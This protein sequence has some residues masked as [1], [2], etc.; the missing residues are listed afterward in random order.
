M[1]THFGLVTVIAGALAGLAVDGSA[2]RFYPDDPVASNHDTQ[3]ASGVTPFEV[4]AGFDA[5]EHMF[6]NPGDPVLNVRALDVNSIDEVP[7]SSWFTNRAGRLPL[8]AAIVARGPN[9]TDGPAPGPWTV[10][11]AKTA[12]IMPGLVVRDAASVDWFIKFDPPGHR[13]MASGAEVVSTRLLWALGLNV[14]ENHVAHVR[15]ADLVLGPEATIRTDNRKRAMRQA[16]VAMVLER[17]ARGADGTYRVMASRRIA[18][19]PLGPFQFHGIRPD[20]PNDYVRHEHRRVLRAYA[21]WAAWL[22]H[23]DAKSSNT[24]DVLVRQD[25]RSVVRHYLLDFGSTLGSAGVKPREPFEGSEYLFERRSL[26]TSV[27]GFGFVVKPWRVGPQIESAEL[28]ALPDSREWRPEAWKPRFP[29]PAFVRARTDDTFWAAARLRTLTPDLI[30]AAVD[31]ARYEDPASRDAVVQFLVDRRQAILRRGLTAINPVANPR[32]DAAGTLTFDNAAVDADVARIP[33]GYRTE[34]FWFDNATGATTRMGERWSRSTQVT[35]PQ[36]IEP[37][38]GRFVKVEIRAT[39]SAEPAW[40]V[41]VHAYFRGSER[42]WG[43]VGFERMPD[44]NPATP[45]RSTRATASTFAPQAV[46]GTNPR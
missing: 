36:P 4:D 39:G 12:G 27:L 33:A 10:I 20:D 37:S 7:D 8:T 23:V 17:A 30:A 40:E 44:G 43:L 15:A 29:N 31:A 35:S 3:D 26:W 6:A 46:A 42:D 32:L 24:L 28:G 13:G 34:W 11:S 21:T 9:L 2:P 25:G 41:P 19:K 18:G 14:P 1:R 16:D 45:V 5:V 38:P 22:N